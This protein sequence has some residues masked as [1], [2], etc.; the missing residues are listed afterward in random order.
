MEPIQPKN[1]SKVIIV[2]RPVSG[3]QTPVKKSEDP[4]VVTDTTSEENAPEE[5]VRTEE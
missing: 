4:D 2:P 5:D 3:S 1:P